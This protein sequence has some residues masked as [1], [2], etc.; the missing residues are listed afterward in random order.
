MINAATGVVGINAQLTAWR[1]QVILSLLS[2]TSS[3]MPAVRSGTSA[4]KTGA[5]AGRVFAGIWSDA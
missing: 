1:E 4:A 2:E 5:T 3:A